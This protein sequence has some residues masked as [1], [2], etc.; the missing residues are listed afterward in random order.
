MKWSAYV[1][2]HAA[3]DLFDLAGLARLQAFNKDSEA[4]LE[5]TTGVGFLLSELLH[6]PRSLS[7]AWESELSHQVAD[8][9]SP[10]ECRRQVFSAVETFLASKA[11]GT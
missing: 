10:E 4:I 7:T 5:Q 8:F 3:R 2:R 9:S 6:I 11:S 1:D